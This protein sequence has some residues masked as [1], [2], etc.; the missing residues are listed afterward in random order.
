MKPG[1][2]GEDAAVRFLRRRGY[3]IL[4]RNYRCPAGEI[5]VVAEQDGVLCFIEVKSRST[6]AFGT[7]AEAVDRRKQRHLAR[8]AAH[9]LMV[10]V[11]DGQVAC[12]FDVVSV[13]PDTEPELI[14]DAFRTAE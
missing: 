2:A 9:Y 13:L 7:P 14:P 5:D 3:R 1:R 11:P 6:L 12:R 8:A 10:H 4:E